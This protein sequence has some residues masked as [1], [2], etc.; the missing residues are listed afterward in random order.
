MFNR[1]KII[2]A[3]SSPRRLMLLNSIGLKVEVIRPDIDESMVEGETPKE[4]VLRAAR[5]KAYTV[6]KKCSIDSSWIIGA[7][8]IVVSGG[9]VL[10]KPKDEAQAKEMLISL[11]GKTHKVLTAFC[12]IGEKGKIERIEA[13]ESFV[14]FK[15][16][17]EDEINWY[18]KT[19]EPMDKAGAYGAQGYGAIFVDRIEGSYNNVVGLPLARLITVLKEEGVISF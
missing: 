9:R 19:G 7:D 6:M 3:S 12:I 8:T 1:N 11:S 4:L 14:T 17:S 13:V 18:V 16:L 5:S 2:L 10:N 15:V